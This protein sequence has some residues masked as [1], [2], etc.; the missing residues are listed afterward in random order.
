MDYEQ[1]NDVLSRAN[2]EFERSELED[3]R[4]YE[5]EGELETGERPT[6]EDLDRIEGRDSLGEMYVGTGG[7][8]PPDFS[9]T[10]DPIS[11]GDEGVDNLASDAEAY[12]SYVAQA[13]SDL[14]AQCG[15]SDDEALAAFEDVA[16]QM[17]EVGA[18]P[19]M[20]DIEV[21]SS[22][23][24]SLWTGAAK[25]GDLMAR[26]IEYVKAGKGQSPVHAVYGQ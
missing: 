21:S 3:L 1:V 17:A 19:M 12:M 22:E 20:P 11:G 26:A 13:A 16:A 18:L 24:I 10:G 4:S 6:T 2:A 9:P 7:T 8:E 5:I 15:I 14:A 25:T 23:E